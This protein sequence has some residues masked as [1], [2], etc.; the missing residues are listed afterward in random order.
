MKEAKLN[1]VFDLMW[2]EANKYFVAAGAL[3]CAN[4]AFADSFQVSLEA[5]G[6]LNTTSQFTSVGVET[7]D[8]LPIQNGGPLTT[9]F[10][11]TLGGYTPLTGFSALLSKANV[12][13]AAAYGGANGTRF[14]TTA[15]TGPIS[16]SF[17][18]AVNYFGLWISAMNN[19]NVISFYSGETFLYSFD[20]QSMTAL[21]T[22][23]YYGNPSG[24]FS[25][26]GASE[27]FAFVNYYDTNGTFDRI[28]LSGN[29]FESDNW[30]V[31]SYSVTSGTPA[32]STV[33]DI[34][35]GNNGRSGFNTFSTIGNGNYAN[36][37]DGGTLLVDQAGTNSANFSITSNHGTI[38][39]GGLASTFSGVFS[40]DTAGTPG[41]LTIVNSGAAGAGSVTL[42]GVNTYTGTTTIDSGARLALSGSGSIA[43][44]SGVVDDGSFD[45]SA[46]TAGASIRTLSGAGSVVT[47]SR[48]LTLTNAAGTFSGVISGSGG[49]TVSGGTEILSGAN[50]Y[51]GPTTVNGG[52]TLA[53]AGNTASMASSS[54]VTNNGTFDLRNANPT[55]VALA[56]SYTQGSTGALRMVASAPGAF[57]RM[58]VGG[59]ASLNGMLELTAAAG[60]YAVGRYT[61]IDATGG[62]TGT[63]STFANNLSSVTRLG[64][65]L[66]YSAN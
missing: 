3:A 27:P 58:T 45:I 25:G 31:G 32:T 56:G 35:S 47:G 1:R 55:T 38:D 13:N 61:L 18:S 7:F 19:G 36:R 34:V 30:T 22:P 63:F 43:A 57:Q 20:T 6:V 40:D 66:G 59:A 64:Y 11:G 53:L 24:P 44:S 42:S 50:T 62:R 23:A 46:T 49:L 65:L 2:S 48:I 51:T 29:G 15:A 21:V 17:N 9:T 52:A 60:D 14:I 41:S 33:P 12:Q 39:Q 28:V 26:Q 8:S 4:A 54:A 10:P 5:A 37:F 16:V